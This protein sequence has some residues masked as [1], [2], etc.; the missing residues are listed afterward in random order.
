[1][2][3]NR[4]GLS[5]HHLGMAVQNP[6]AAMAFLAPLGYQRGVAVFDPEQRAHLAMCSHTSM[7]YVELIWAGAQPS[8]IDNLIR[9]SET[10]IYH[11]CYIAADVQASLAAM[12]REGLEVVEVSPPKPALLF[13]GIAVSFHAVSGFGLIE[14]MHAESLPARSLSAIAA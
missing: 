7:P 13:G 12:E 5:F 2:N 10:A 14:L 4:F 8:P 11:V 3:T 6:D 9:R 1:M